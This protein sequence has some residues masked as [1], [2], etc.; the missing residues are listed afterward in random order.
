[1]RVQNCVQII[2]LRGSID[3]LGYEIIVRNIEIKDVNI[4]TKYIKF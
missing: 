1:M 2:F 3:V 4:K